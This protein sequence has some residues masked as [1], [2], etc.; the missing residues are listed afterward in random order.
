MVRP[1]HNPPPP[2]CKPEP[3]WRRE[4]FSSNM[5][6]PIYSVSRPW[7]LV[8]RHH[9]GGGRRQNRKEWISP[10]SNKIQHLHS[11]Q[12]GFQWLSLNLFLLIDQYQ[13]KRVIS[14]HKKQTVQQCYYNI[15]PKPDIGCDPQPIPSV[16]YLDNKVSEDADFLSSL[17]SL[18]PW[19]K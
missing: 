19:F 15:L 17:L 7:N 12:E 4:R 5:A 18:C 3:G 16:S 1:N 10:S 13:Q 9:T 8:Y 14:W 6:V 2:P 11:A